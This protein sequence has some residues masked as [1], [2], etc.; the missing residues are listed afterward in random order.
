MA[1]IHNFLAPSN[2]KFLS[3]SNYLLSA[4]LNTVCEYQRGPETGGRA[5][6][7]AGT[8]GLLVLIVRRCLAII[9]DRLRQRTIADLLGGQCDFPLTA[10]LFTDSLRVVCALCAVPLRP[11]AGGE[12]LGN[13][14]EN[15]DEQNKDG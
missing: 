3:S 2:K 9:I 8:V 1:P 4:P 7:G 11:G 10:K 12:A 13:V 5:R 14:P 6:P 15:K